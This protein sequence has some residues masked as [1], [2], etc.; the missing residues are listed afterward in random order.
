VELEALKAELKKAQQDAEQQKAAVKK[1]SEELAEEKATQ[2]K[3]QARVVEV[4]EDLKGLYAKHDI[5]Q[6]DQKKK[7]AELEKLSSACTEAQT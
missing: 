1:A 7:A 6:A 3:D 2:S 4:E 5:L